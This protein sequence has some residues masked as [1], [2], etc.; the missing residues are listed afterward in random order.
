M[1]ERFASLPIR[2]LAMAYW[3]SR[4]ASG[5]DAGG[6]RGASGGS[7]QITAGSCERFIYRECL[8]RTCAAVDSV[9]ALVANGRAA[10]GSRPSA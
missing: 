7:G 2:S 3:M 1:V 4:A 5:G 8:W 10:F 6:P 9:P